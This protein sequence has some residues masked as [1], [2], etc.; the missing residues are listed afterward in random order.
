MKK[1]KKKVKFN[2][3]W[4]MLLAAFAFVLIVVYNKNYKTSNEHTAEEITS[5]ILQNPSLSFVENG[6]INEEKLNRVK[7][8]SYE[9]IKT[10]LKTQSDFCIY[11]ED[12]QGNII[13]SLGAPAWKENGVC[14]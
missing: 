5:K 14:S 11:I 10:S 1:E 12:E 2:I 6:L 9:E 8:M 13:L 4:L 3:V 7:S